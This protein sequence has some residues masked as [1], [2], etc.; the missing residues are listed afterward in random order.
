MYSSSNEVTGYEFKDKTK[1]GN[2]EIKL[3]PGLFV[4]R[5]KKVIK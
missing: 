4:F 2:D 5:K 1:A 3:V